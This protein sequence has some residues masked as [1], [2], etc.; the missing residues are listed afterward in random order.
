MGI[1]LASGDVQVGDAIMVELPAQSE[2]L[3]V[4]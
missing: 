3:E 4:V 2:P 1:V